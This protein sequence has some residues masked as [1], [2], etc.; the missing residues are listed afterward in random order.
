MNVKNIK[1]KKKKERNICG[2]PGSFRI[3]K[4][5]EKRKENRRKEKRKRRKTKPNEI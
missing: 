4:L 3:E 1:M 2:F 5:N